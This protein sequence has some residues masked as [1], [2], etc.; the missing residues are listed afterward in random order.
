MFDSGPASQDGWNSEAISIPS[1]SVSSDE[2]VYVRGDG[3]SL[4][5]DTDTAEDWKHHWSI[6]GGMGTLCLQTTFE[7]SQA[8]IT[9]IIGPQHGL[10]EL[11]Q[12]IDDSQTSLRIQLYQMQDAYLVQALLDALQRGVTVEI[13][14]DQDVTI[15]TFGVKLIYSTRMTLLTLLFKQAPLYMNSIPMAMNLI[16]TCTARL[17]SETPAVFGCHQAIGSLHPCLLLVLEAT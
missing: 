11:K 1:S 7:E 15:V 14:L 12:F 3:C 13:M 9:P 2:F 4:L 16:F 5:P 8:L 17:Q 10:L 6:T